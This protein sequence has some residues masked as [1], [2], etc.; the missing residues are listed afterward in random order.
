MSRTLCGAVLAAALSFAACGSKPEEV[1]DLPIE[2]QET[3]LPVERVG[4]EEPLPGTVLDTT[5]G[6]PNFE[7]E[8]TQSLTLI[9]PP[10]VL[11]IPTSDS[12]A[13]VAYYLTQTARTDAGIPLAQ[14]QGAGILGKVLLGAFARKA[15]DGGAGIDFLFVRRGLHRYYACGTGQPKTLTDFKRQFG[16][17]AQW[18]T[19]TIEK[20]RPKAPGFRQLHVGAEGIYVAET[21]SA[22]AGVRETEIILANKHRADGALT[23]WAYDAQGHATNTSTFSTNT[24]GTTESSAPYTCMACHFNTQPWRYDKLVP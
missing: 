3:P 21:L 5:E 13:A 6:L 19:T 23:F 22:D 10:Q 17:F 2:I 11:P 7:G 18:P 14:V 12:Q 8:L 15:A 20:S 4:C 16:D 1:D 24:G 9:S